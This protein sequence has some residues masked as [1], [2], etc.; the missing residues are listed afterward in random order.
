MGLDP[1]ADDQIAGGAAVLTGVALAAQGDGLAVVDP[2]GNGDGNGAL[3]PLLAGAVTVFAGILDDLSG[4]VAGGTGPLALHGAEHSLLHRSYPTGPP[5]GGAGFCRRSFFCTGSVT[6]RTVFLPGNRNA[7]FASED[8]L[9]K[10]Q[11][12]VGIHVV[13]RNCGGTPL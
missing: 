10:G 2:G 5:A 8:R 6:F 13:S 11:R 3:F 12:Q 4:S 7:L 9:L 1:H